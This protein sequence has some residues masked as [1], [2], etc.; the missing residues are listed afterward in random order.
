[1]TAPPAKPTVPE[2]LPLV[3]AFY[4][5]PGNGVG[6]S[7]HIVLDDDNY[8]QHHI[9]WCVTYAEAHRDT[10][11]AALAR[12][13]AAMSPT[14]RHKLYV[15]RGSVQWDDPTAPE[16]FDALLAEF[17]SN[18]PAQFPPLPEPTPQ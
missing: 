11:G 15:K 1:M 2:V 6:G 7:L 12:I 16:R 4:G 3:E 14:Q 10:R 8:E 5:I 18:V 17:L 13:L 9:E